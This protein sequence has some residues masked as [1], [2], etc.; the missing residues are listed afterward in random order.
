[1]LATGLACQPSL[2]RL[3]LWGI[4][5]S[6][7][8]LQ[9][10]VRGLVNCNLE[11]L[12]LV[13]SGN[14]LM[15]SVSGMKSLGSLVGRTTSMRS[16]CLRESLTDIGLHYLV[17]GIMQHCSLT[18][19][20][21]SHNH[22]ITANGL[23]S[24]S[25]L[26]RAE[27]CSLCILYL[28]GIN[29]GND[30]AAVLAG[31][32]I[33][34]KSLTELRFN[35]TDSGITARGWA[36]FSRLLCDT[37]SVNSTYLS[38]HTL[39]QVGDYGITNTPSDILLFSRLNKLQFRAAAICKILHS[40]P[41]IDVTPLF[42]FNLKCLPLVVAWLEKAKQYLDNVNESTESFQGRCLSAVYKFIRGM[43]QLV[44]DGYRRQ[45]KDIQSDAKKKRKFDLT[46]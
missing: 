38:N 34:N 30:G 43:P 29:F 31:G 44:A 27:H 18:E 45:K 20:Y 22:F 28:Y 16:L 39:Q 3:D 14:M 36:A 10:L 12:S 32:L 9:D 15:D 37:S 23:P 42:Q 17:E 7:R 5:I 21:L 8:G 35:P 33:G 4:S 11:K 24:L 1:M 26:F 46:L 25:S 41:D 6:D 13:F 2:K 19:L 40:H